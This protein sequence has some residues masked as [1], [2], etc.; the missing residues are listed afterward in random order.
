MNKNLTRRTSNPCHNYNNN[1]YSNCCY[2][3]NIIYSQYKPKTCKCCTI[4]VLNFKVED[5]MHLIF[6]DHLD[7]AHLE[8]KIDNNGHLILLS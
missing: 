6:D 7:C 5:N 3:S 4:S 1:I 2:D 8:F